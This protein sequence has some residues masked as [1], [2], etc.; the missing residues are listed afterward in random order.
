M[1]WGAIAALVVGHSI[2][3]IGILASYERS[4]NLLLLTAVSALPLAQ[5]SLLAVWVT[6]GRSLSYVRFA[7]AGVVATVL[8]A[9]ECHSL[10]LQLPDERSAAHALALA[11]QIVLIGGVLATIRLGRWLVEHRSNSCDER[12]RVQFSV[13]SLLGWVAATAV[14]LGA[15]KLSLNRAAWP[16][17]VIRGDS[18][19][20]GAAVGAYNAFFALTVLGSV[21]RGRRWYAFLAQGFAA[22]VLVG[23]VAS[24]QSVV[25]RTVFNGNGGVDV[26]GWMLLAGFQGLYLLVTLVPVRLYKLS[27]R[28]EPRNGTSTRFAPGQAGLPDT[29]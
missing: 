21:S 18:F 19:L 16:I 2:A 4:P 17:D 11:V 8:W 10:N 15:W 28:K 22:L 25:L 7:V 12:D 14:V 20:F 13:G 5:A 26:V 6:L 27:C 23:V 1:R 24:F 29:A 3:T 9:V